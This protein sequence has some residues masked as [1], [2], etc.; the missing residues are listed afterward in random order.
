V[1][2]EHQLLFNNENDYVV[3]TDDIKTK[4]RRNQSD[5][6][7]LYSVGILLNRIKYLESLLT[8]NL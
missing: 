6:A 4:Y 1:S 3:E 8:H 2:L 5:V 7:S